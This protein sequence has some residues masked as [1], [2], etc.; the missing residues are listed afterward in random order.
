MTADKIDDQTIGIE[1]I[2]MGSEGE[3]IGKAEGLAVFVPGAITGDLAEVRITTQKKNFAKAELIRIVK[4]SRYRTEPFCR[5]AGEC[6]GCSLQSMSYEGQL[7]LKQKMVRDRLER[8]GGI[9]DPKVHKVQG[10]K[11][12]LRYRN[13]AQ[14]PIQNGQ[15]GFYKAKSHSLVSVYECGI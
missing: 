15:V 1:I 10:M 4:P 3:G 8:I 6:G 11:I 2:D 14:F 5:Y 7:L 9:Q 12:P 13:K